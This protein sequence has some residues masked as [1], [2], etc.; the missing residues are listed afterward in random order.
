MD[1]LHIIEAVHVSVKV[2]AAASWFYFFLLYLCL[3]G[4][5]GSGFF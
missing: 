3:K 1:V 4:F 2:K 5:F